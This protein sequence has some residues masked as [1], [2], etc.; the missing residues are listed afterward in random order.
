V[1]RILILL[2]VAALFV[3]AMTLMVG[4]SF[5]TPCVNNT[6]NPHCEKTNPGGQPKGCASNPQCKTSFNHPTK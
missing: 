2:A 1:R 4:S 3:V 6:N 5:A